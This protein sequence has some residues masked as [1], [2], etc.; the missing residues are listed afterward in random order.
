M[1]DVRCKRGVNFDSDYH[2]LMA[3][4]Q[5]RIS[6]TKTH[7]GQKVKKYVQSLE[8]KKVKQALRNKII[9]VDLNESTCAVEDRKE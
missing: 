1:R 9:V 6:M 7:K 3:K 4:F 5:A 8:N 2:L